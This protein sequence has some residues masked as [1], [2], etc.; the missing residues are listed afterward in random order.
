[1]TV[2]ARGPGAPVARFRW[3]TYRGGAW[4]TCDRCSQRWRRS[5]M[6]LEWDRLLVCPPC[7][8]PRPPTMRPPAV[9]PEGI[10]FPDARPPQDDP[11]RLVDDSYL[12]A[13]AGTMAVTDGVYPTYPNK[14]KPPIGA[15]SPQSVTV[16]PIPKNTP[17]VNL[18]TD[19]VTLRTGPVFPPDVPYI[20]GTGTSPGPVPF[21]GPPV[22]PF[23]GND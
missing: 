6:R 14:Q 17:P 8:D 23:T 15:F 10:A 1:M 22:P 16:D 7:L 4:A 12:V 13:Q 20:A 2:A 18:V 19:D 5:E 9:Y 11:D 3:D 21:S